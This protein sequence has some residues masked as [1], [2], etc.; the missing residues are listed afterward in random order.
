MNNRL[1]SAFIAV[2]TKPYALRRDSQKRGPAREISTLELFELRQQDSRKGVDDGD[3]DDA[4]R[5]RG[6]QGRCQKLP[7]GNPGGT[8]DNEFVVSGQ[9]QKR[10]YAAEHDRE[11]HGFLGEERRAQ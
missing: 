4:E 3:V 10:E 9:A 5:D 11:R 2:L 6:D 7:N 8:Q 1:T